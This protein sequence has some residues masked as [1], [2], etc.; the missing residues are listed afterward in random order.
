M[1]TV[2]STFDLDGGGIVRLAPIIPGIAAIAHIAIWDHQW[3]RRAPVIRA[4]G[5]WSF[6]K[7]SLQRISCF[8]PSRHVLSARTAAAIGFTQEGKM[9]NAI[10][11]NDNGQQAVD[12]CLVYG[13]LANEV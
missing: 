7:W 3:L 12:D 11:Y 10:V 5:A 8:V 6:K 1:A 2:N 4:I 13:L 9:R